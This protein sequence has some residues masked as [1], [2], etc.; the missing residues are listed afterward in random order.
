MAS[1][2]SSKSAESESA[3]N[4]F[5]TEVK[6]IEQVDSVLTS[7]QQIDRLHRPG[8]TYFN[9]NPF[10]VLQIDP[11]CTMADVKKKYRQLSILVHPDKNPADPD[12]S[13]KSF[14]AVNKAYKTLENEEGYK[15]CKE[16]VEEAKTR[17]ED[18]M[19]QKRKTL[20]KEG[21]PII[22][23]EDDT[24]QYK[25]AVYVQTCKLFA[26]LERLRQEREA[27]DM[28]E[29]KR[30]AEEEETEKET[31]KIKEEWNKN[32]EES[33]SDRV[34]SWRNWKTGS[35]KTKTKTTKSGEFKPPKHKAEQR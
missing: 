16:I 19:K 13:Q 28:H 7:K 23:P 30:K 4:L 17:T 3:F 2:E 18:M 1:G 21:K 6:A 26:D 34:N 29:R 5:Y 22:I 11:D 9:L 20:K 24:E 27:K 8:S 32:F 35:K 15:R 10:E 31:K 12:R 33:R 14:E 25:H